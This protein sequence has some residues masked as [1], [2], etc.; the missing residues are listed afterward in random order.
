[1]NEIKTKKKKDAHTEAKK[2]RESFTYYELFQSGVDITSDIV[3]TVVPF[4]FPPPIPSLS[5]SHTSSSSSSSSPTHVSP[6]LF[7]LSLFVILVFLLLLLQLNGQL[8]RLTS[9]IDSINHS[10]YG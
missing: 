9:T 6:P 3:F 5:V 7:S 4:S 8:V 1:M 10:S 2:T